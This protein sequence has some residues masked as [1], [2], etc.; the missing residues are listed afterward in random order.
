MTRLS[1][2]KPTTTHVTNEVEKLKNLCGLL[3]PSDGKK[4]RIS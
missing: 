1:Q 4:K 2:A 3:I